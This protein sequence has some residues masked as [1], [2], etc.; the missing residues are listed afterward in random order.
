MSR[1][2][3]SC[4]KVKL[5]GEFYR[6]TKDPQGRQRKCKSCIG[7]YARARK[8]ANPSLARDQYLRREYGISLEEYE[9]MLR[10]QDGACAI[11]GNGGKLH[12]DHCHASGRIRG[13][14]CGSCNRALG[15]FKD[16]VGNLAT[17]I[18]YLSERM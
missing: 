3:N 17:A 7:D 4:R 11:C 6:E 9:R 15:L 5:L 12:V 16:N 13:L 2:C 10:R 18:V 8:S 14:L 1:K